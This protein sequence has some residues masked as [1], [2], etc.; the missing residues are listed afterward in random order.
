MYISVS[1]GLTKVLPFASLASEADLVT[2]T[3]GGGGT[4]IASSKLPVF[5]EKSASNSGERHTPRGVAALAAGYA[6]PEWLVDALSVSWLLLQNARPGK[7]EK[8]PTTTKTIRI[9]ID[10]RNNGEVERMCVYL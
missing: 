9:E 4:A 8:K 6:S 10:V 7:S 5:Q 3:G 1:P 2:E